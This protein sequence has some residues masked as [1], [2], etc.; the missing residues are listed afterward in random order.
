MTHIPVEYDTA[1]LWATLT[2]FI[3]M[4]VGMI[5]PFRLVVA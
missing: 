4:F 3:G 1:F 5:S 2:F